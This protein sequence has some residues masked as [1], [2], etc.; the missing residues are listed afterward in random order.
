[1]ILLWVF[2]APGL[3]KKPGSIFK[4]SNENFFFARDFFFFNILKMTK[5]ITWHNGVVNM[6]IFISHLEG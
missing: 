2:I 6:H 1:M 3:W 4:L 5:M